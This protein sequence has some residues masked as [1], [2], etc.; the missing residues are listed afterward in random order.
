MRRT[1]HVPA[2]RVLATLA[3]AFVSG[4][5]AMKGDIRTLQDEIR[6]V[7]AR[8]DSLMTE[9]RMQTAQTQDTLRTQGDQM[10]DLRGDI[11]RQLQQINQSLARIEALAGENQRG[12]TAVRDQ[13]ANMRRMPSGGMPDDP[14][15]SDSSGGGESLI[16]GA[17]NPD[18]LW[19]VAQAQYQRGSL[20]SASA[21]FQDFIEEHSGD[22][23][24]PAAHFFLADILWQ[25]D[26]PEDALEAFQEIQSL[27]PTHE[28]VPEALYRI[29][30]LQLELDDTDAARNTLERIVNTYPGTTMAMLARDKL[31][32]IG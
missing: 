29:A 32:E 8:Q 21:A 28:R 4:G 2:A 20:N 7:S 19:T 31:E 16:G 18:E 26:R 1:H 17:G 27:F 30:E 23:R 10:F 5:C 6:A 14:M 9:I 22:P 11:N 13:L 15:V 24:V 12:L 25:Q 3:V